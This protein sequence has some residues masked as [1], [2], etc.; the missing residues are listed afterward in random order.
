MTADVAHAVAVRALNETLEDYPGASAADTR[1]VFS[2]R[3][4]NL[5]GMPVDYAMDCRPLSH[6]LTPRE[7]RKL[8]YD[9]A[10]LMLP[11]AA[12]VELMNGLDNAM[13]L[14]GTHVTKP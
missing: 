12:V 7:V 1:A 5:L 2:A 11:G 8:V 9:V 14:A 10:D 3:L 6:R 4:A 13:A